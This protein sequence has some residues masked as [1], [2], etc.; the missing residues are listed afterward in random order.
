MRRENAGSDSIRNGD[1][2]SKSVKIGDISISVQWENNQVILILENCGLNEE[3]IYIHFQESSSSG[4]Q[5]LKHFQWSDED[6]Q[7]F[8]HQRTVALPKGFKKWERFYC[9]QRPPESVDLKEVDLKELVDE[10]ERQAKTELSQPETEPS[11]FNPERLS[12]SP[13]KID[14]DSK[15]D[16][17]TNNELEQA[18]IDYQQ[19]TETPVQE[20]R[21]QMAELARAYEDGEPIDFV[22][23][24]NPTA[25]Q[26]V[27]LILNWMACE[28]GEW[29]TELEQ[30]YMADADL[31]QTLRYAEQAIKDKL[32]AIRSPSLLALKTDISRNTKLSH[33][34]DEYAVWVTRFKRK[35]SDYEMKHKVSESEYDQFI[36]Q[37]IKD[38]LFNGV[39]RFVAFEQLPERL[40]KFLQ[41]VGY[42][43]V[44]IEVGTTK[45]DSRVH[46]IQGSRQTC[47]EPG[48]IVEVILPGLRRKTDG[49][50]VQ[51]PVVIRGE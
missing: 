15:P 49:E 7:T 23:I 9:Q 48:T 1:S 30:S 26:N 47:V 10:T 36:P 13:L 3:K 44:P 6:P 42:E 21:E 12:D 20:T 24:E 39:V 35:L 18:P 2:P 25:S 17:E 19:E 22:D 38:R 28:L 31:V 41:L 29:K 14:E 4:T 34:Q 50:I 5:L 46:E 33:I 27:L 45:A 51:K 43:V 32:K 11:R 40:D 8:E 16:I 37:F